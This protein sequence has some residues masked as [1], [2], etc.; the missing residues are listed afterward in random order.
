MLALYE[1]RTVWPAVEF[2]FYPKE[3]V[4]IEQGE[5]CI[6]LLQWQEA[7]SSSHYGL[8]EIDEIGISLDSQNKD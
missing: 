1:P 4:A 7:R 6:W 8:S 2:Q 3:W 5:G